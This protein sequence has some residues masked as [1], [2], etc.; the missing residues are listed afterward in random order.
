MN[1]I[2]KIVEYLEETEQIVVKFC[3]QN[4]PKPI[5]DYPPVAIDCINL[6]LYDYHQFVAS[7][8]RYGVDL[9]LRQEA[10]EPTL[11]QNIPSEV[12]EEP[13]I[14]KQI[15]RVISL[16]SQELIAT[17]YRMNKIKLD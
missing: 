16:N 15:N 10:E 9:I 6:D 4:S 12:I 2:F 14:K 11:S 13:D 1:L 17:T 3:R 5:D 7:L 8:M